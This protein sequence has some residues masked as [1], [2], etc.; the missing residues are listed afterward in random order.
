MLAIPLAAALIVFV[1]QNTGD[2]VVR[3]TVWKVH[4]PLA[5]VVLVAILAAVVLAEI[6]GV[7]WRHRRRTLLSR[8]ESALAERAERAAVTAP[9]DSTESTTPDPPPQVPADEDAETPSA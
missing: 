8:R 9:A 3:W 7:I 4:A 2:V 6:A 5:A 1:A